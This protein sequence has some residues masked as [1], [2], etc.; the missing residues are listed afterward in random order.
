MLNARFRSI[1]ALV[2]LLVLTGCGGGSRILKEPVELELEQPVAQAA[3]D[4]L[5]AT[6]D[7]VIVKDG[8]G[9]WSKNAWWDEYMIRV[10]NVSDEPVTVSSVQVIDWL[11]APV[12]AGGNRKELVKASK[13]TAKRYKDYDIKVEPGAGTGTMM[14]AGTGVLLIGGVA[15]AIEVGAAMGTLFS[16]GAATASTPAIVG[17]VGTAAVVAAPVLIVGGIVKGANNSAVN[18]QILARQ[19]ELPF[20]LAPGEGRSISVFFPV[21]P[22]PKAVHFVYET[23]A[24]SSILE[25]QTTEVLSGLH[26]KTP[27]D[28]VVVEDSGNASEAASAAAE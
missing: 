17:V 3:D 5:A 12:T 1:F 2:T 25:V 16:A 15:A 8:P 21:S 26:L 6:L 7:W 13:L 22:S 20:E 24:G 11:D 23:E 27:I 14:A 28:G 10:A 9:T 4:R 19:V 18:K